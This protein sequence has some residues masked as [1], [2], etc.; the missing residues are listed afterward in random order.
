MGVLRLIFA[1]S[2]H[3]DSTY[4][5]T[6]QSLEAKMLQPQLSSSKALNRKFFFYFLIWLRQTDRSV[7]CD[8]IWKVLVTIFFSKVTQIFGNVLAK[9]EK[10]H[11]SGKFWKKLFF[12]HLITLTQTIKFKK[13]ST[14]SCH[15]DPIDKMFKIFH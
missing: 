4:M 2:H 5:T 1:F 11:F 10:H 8:Q 9:C 15:T 12:K 3:C 13:N 7:Q 6:L 14:K